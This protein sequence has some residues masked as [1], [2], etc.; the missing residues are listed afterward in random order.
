[1][2][3]HTPVCFKPKTFLVGEMN[4]D[5]AQVGDISIEPPAV[6]I[7]A[8]TAVIVVASPESVD[9]EAHGEKRVASG[10]LAVYSCPAARDVL[11][12]ES[13]ENTVR[14]DAPALPPPSAPR[15]TSFSVL[16]ILDPNKFTSK[17]QS[18]SRTSCDSGCGFG[19]ENRGEDSNHSTDQKAYPEEYDCKKSSG[20]LGRSS[21]NT[22][23]SP[24]GELD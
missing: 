6:G 11:Q 24:S 20:L 4:R 5:K 16:D 23:F 18:L 13:R 15:T 9:M 3:F 14:Q 10:E 19:T 12:A 7:A 8:Q 17:R 2:F 22:H 21:I 1:M